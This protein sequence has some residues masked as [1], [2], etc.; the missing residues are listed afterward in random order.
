MSEGML[1]LECGCGWSA[2]GTPDEVVAATQEHSQ[3][4]HNMQATRD[5]VLARATPVASTSAAAGATQ[6]VVDEA[7][8]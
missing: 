5:E 6:P 1:R 8:S 7:A 4:V 3:R 2:T